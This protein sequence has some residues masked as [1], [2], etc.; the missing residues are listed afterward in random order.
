VKFKATYARVVRQE[1]EVVFDLDVPEGTDEA[2]ARDVAFGHAS[3][4]PFRGEPESVWKTV[5]LEQ[6]YLD[7][8]EVLDPTQDPLD[9]RSDTE[10]S[11]VSVERGEVDWVGWVVEVLTETRGTVRGPAWKTDFDHTPFVGERV[12]VSLHGRVFPW[13][14]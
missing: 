6:S 3:D 4:M 8:V 9:A 7:G 12:V 13:E 5:G 10:G 1:R 2:E 14:S 11:V